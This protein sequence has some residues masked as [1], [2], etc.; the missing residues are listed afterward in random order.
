MVNKGKY[1]KRTK[2]KLFSTV[3]LDASEQ[4]HRAAFSIGA[5]PASWD[6]RGAKTARL[7]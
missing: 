5:G 3:V 4:C 1:K 2:Y 7:C 6:I